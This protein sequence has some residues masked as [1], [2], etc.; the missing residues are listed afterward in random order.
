MSK[1]TV[2]KDASFK[3][4]VENWIF[5]NAT[6]L[7][8]IELT[9]TFV[10]DGM[11]NFSQ[12]LSM[13]FGMLMD[14]FVS[15]LNSIEPAPRLVYP[16]EY[17]LYLDIEPTSLHSYVL[18]TTQIRLLRMNGDKP[19]IGIDLLLKCLDSAMDAIQSTLFLIKKSHEVHDYRLESMLMDE[20]NGYLMYLMLCSRL[21]SADIFSITNKQ[22]AEFIANEYLDETNDSFKLKL[23]EIDDETFL[24]PALIVSTP[25]FYTVRMPYMANIPSGDIVFG[26][27][28]GRA[29]SVCDP[30]L[31]TAL[32]EFAKAFVRNITY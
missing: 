24:D 23:G 1:D 20:D 30:E 13:N 15:I 22:G 17:D 21:I 2:L 16:P 14:R 27:Q 4:V 3:N 7:G 19:G 10:R 6:Y 31:A 25:L 28:E 12:T 8:V 18:N 26:T 11:P 5:E 9:E 29:Y 32:E